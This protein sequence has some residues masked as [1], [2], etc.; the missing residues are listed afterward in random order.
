MDARK[1][2]ALLVSAREGSFTRA[3]QELGVTQSGLTH[4]MNALEQEVGVPLLER[5]H[6]GTRL[7][8]Q[9][10]ALEEAARAFVE[11]G[12]VLEQQAENLRC[13]E[14]RSIRVGAYSSMALHWLPSIL[15]QFRQSCP[16]VRV[17]VEMGGIEELYGHVRSGEMD[18]AFVS[19][20]DDL[21][22]EFYPLKEDVLVAILPPEEQYEGWEKFPVT[23][24]EDREFLMPSLGFTRDIMPMFRRHQVRPRIRRTTVD[25]PVV[26]SMVAHGLGVSIM[27]ELIMTGRPKT[28][29]VLPIDP[30]A[31]RELG[32][33]VRSR[34]E[35]KPA[36][37]DLIRCARE[38]VAA[39]P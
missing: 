33:I 23:A 4:M 38:T 18:L 12:K 22:S 19:R 29:K 27:T 1:W 25:D 6:Y 35:L 5:G 39:M 7:T 11:A 2:E 37:Q 30:R 16:D 17:D 3:A 10:Q 24:F 32:I 9:G 8:E 34:K 36:A 28:V 26:I 14:D 15:Q 31:F 20:Q 13:R 21:R